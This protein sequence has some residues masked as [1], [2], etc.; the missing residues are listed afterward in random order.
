MTAS[1]I[2]TLDH[3]V[4]K[5]FFVFSVALFKTIFLSK[6]SEWLSKYPDGPPDPTQMPSAWRDRLNAAIAAGKIPDIPVSSGPAFGNPSYPAGHDPLSPEICSAT[7][8]C[9]IDGDI[10]DAPAGDYGLGFDDGPLPVS[11]LYHSASQLNCFFCLDFRQ[12]IRFSQGEQRS[13]HRLPNRHH[14]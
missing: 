8:K 6:K 3:Q 5:S 2:P 11:T 14:H 9:R 1:T 4:R 10:W 7:Y 12:T 13:C